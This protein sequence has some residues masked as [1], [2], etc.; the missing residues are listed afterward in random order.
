MI[1]IPIAA[2]CDELRPG[3]ESTGLAEI[4]SGKA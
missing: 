2:M 1:E 4:N 3:M